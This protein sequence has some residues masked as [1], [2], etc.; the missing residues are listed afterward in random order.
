MVKDAVRLLLL[1][2]SSQ[3]AF[4]ARQLPCSDRLSPPA[5]VA[6]TQQ[7]SAIIVMFALC[8]VE[9][10]QK[11]SSSVSARRLPLAVFPS[12]TA[13]ATNAR[14]A[15]VVSKTGSRRL[16]GINKIINNDKN[17]RFQWE[18][19]NAQAGEP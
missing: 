17:V 3:R 7:L 13:P 6:T 8:A 16:T 9:V 15:A 19:V 1:S 18:L 14:V 11:T 2:R 10:A 5:E 12:K 4:Q